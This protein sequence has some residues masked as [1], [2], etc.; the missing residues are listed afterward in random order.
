MTIINMIPGM[1]YIYH[2]LLLIA[3]SSRSNI[4]KRLPRVASMLCMCSCKMH[5]ISL[6]SEALCERRGPQQYN[7]DNGDNN[8]IIQSCVQDSAVNRRM[9]YAYQLTII[10]FANA[11]SQ[12]NLPTSYSSIIATV[13]NILLL[14][15]V[16]LYMRKSVYYQLT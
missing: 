5:V 1:R 11:I 2:Y 15:L 4:Q 8:R 13:I 12:E 7:P 6:I 16:Q 3:H 9:G 10:L 14:Y